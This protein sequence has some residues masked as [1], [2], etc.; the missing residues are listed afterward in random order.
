MRPRSHMVFLLYVLFAVASSVALRSIAPTY[1]TNQAV[2]FAAGLV[3][4]WAMSSVPFWF[5]RQYRWWAYSGVVAILLITL[6]IGT[7]TKGSLSWIRF[8]TYRFQPSELVKPILMLVL[9]VWASHRSLGTLKDWLQFAVIAG[10]PVGLIMLQPDLGT[11]IVIASGVVGIALTARPKRSYLLGSIGVAA[12]VIA[13]SWL[14]LLQPY[15]K[16]RILT[17]V[18]PSNDP[19]GSGYNR[20]QALIAVG[21][22]GVLGQGLGQG[23]QSTLRFLPERQTDFIYASVGE[24]TGFVGSAAVLLAYGALF[25]WIWRVMGEFDRADA[26]RVTW[27]CAALLWTQTT[28]NIGMNIGLLPITGVTLPLM[29]LGGTSIISTAAILGLIESMRRSSSPPHS[30]LE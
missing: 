29:S 18:Q 9:G 24:K 17:F 20:Q 19:L 6:I 8:G 15:Q 16:D 2:F 5:V 11:S 26:L 1:G 14:F 25:A 13:L 10:I 4:L 3:V 28:I 22:G 7:A 30:H 23:S 12:I 27:G 21:S